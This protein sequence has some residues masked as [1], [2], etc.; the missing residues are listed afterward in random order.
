M[1]KRV[2]NKQRKKRPIYRQSSQ[3][4][5]V[6]GAW[7]LQEGK[8]L[9]RIS[10]DDDVPD[11]WMSSQEFQ[12]TVRIDFSRQTLHV[13]EQCLQSWKVEIAEQEVVRHPEKLGL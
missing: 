11:L 7:S 9:M 3:M 10:F 8:H 6:Y 5:K 13:E 12:E 4:A 1:N 2:S